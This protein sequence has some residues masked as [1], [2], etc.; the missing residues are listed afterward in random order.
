M[1]K[2]IFLDV[3]GVLNRHH[4]RYYTRETSPQGFIG[5]GQKHLYWLKYIVDKTGAYIVLSS[6][7]KDCFETDDC[8][9]NKVNCPDGTYLANRLAKAG[10]R[11][12]ERTDDS[13]VGNE[14]STGRGFGIRKYLKAHPEVTEYVILDDVWF[15]DFNRELVPHLLWLEY[16]LTRRPAEK[17]IKCLNGVLIDNEKAKTKA[18]YYE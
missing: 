10:C 2:V 14:R 6:D 9:P 1:S 3:D 15:L 4:E 17:A 13:S 16:P 8:D 11:I 5:I 12:V 7:W 18:G